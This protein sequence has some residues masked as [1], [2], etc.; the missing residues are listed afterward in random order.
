MLILLVHG[1]AP[2]NYH[3]VALRNLAMAVNSVI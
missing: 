1:L 2:V 3:L